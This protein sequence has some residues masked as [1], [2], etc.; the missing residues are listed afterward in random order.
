MTPASVYP[1]PR[2]SSSYLTIRCSTTVPVR[3]CLVEE[4]RHKCREPRPCMDRCGRLLSQNLHGTMDD[5]SREMVTRLLLAASCHHSIPCTAWSF[6][7]HIP[8]T[9]ILLAT[10][11]ASSE[12]F[13]KHSAGHPSVSLAFYAHWIMLP[14]LLSSSWFLHARQGGIYSLFS[15]GVWTLSICFSLP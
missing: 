14:L 4:P 2:S 9:R 3:V 11:D 6:F 1:S 13:L 10:S 12:C 7:S 15:T 8:I 5:T